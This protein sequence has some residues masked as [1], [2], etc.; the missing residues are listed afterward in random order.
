M[1]SSEDGVYSLGAYAKN[2]CNRLIEQAEELVRNGMSE[3]EAI[4]KVEH[5]SSK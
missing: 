4:R 1:H 2:Q 3:G 5:D